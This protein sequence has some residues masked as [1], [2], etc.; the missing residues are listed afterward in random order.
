MGTPHYF[1]KATKY[2]STYQA[3]VQD[4]H[5]PMRSGRIRVYCK[6][7]YGD[8][9]SPW[10]Q[11]KHQ[12][13]LWTIP[14]EGSKVW[15]T[16]RHGDPRYPIWEGSWTTFNPDTM[17]PEFYELS[18]GPYKDDLRDAKDHT[19]PFDVDDHD[20]GHDHSGGKWWN[21][22][23][24]GLRFPS[25]AGLEVNE[26]PGEQRMFVTDR[27]GQSLE[28]T[29]DPITP[30]DPHDETRVGGEYDVPDLDPNSVLSQNENVR[31]RTSLKARHTQKLEW[32]VGQ[33]DLEETLTLESLNIAGDEGTRFRAENSELAFGFKLE[34]FLKSGETQGYE[35]RVDP[36]SITTNHWQRLYDEHG[37]EFRIH[38]D[39]QTPMRWMKLQN[40]LGDYWRVDWD[41]RLMEWTDHNGQSIYYNTDEQV[42]N[43]YIEIKNTPG[44]KIRMDQDQLFLSLE[45]RL[46]NKILF[47]AQTDVFTIDHHTGQNVTMDATGVSVA[48]S[49]GSTVTM[50]AAG[51]VSVNAPTSI[52]LSA[53]GSSITLSASG[54]ALAP[55]T[56]AT[57]NGKLIAVGGNSVIGTDSAGHT[58]VTSSITATG[59]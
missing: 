35:A 59:A 1:N 13:H 50:D 11:P 17:P 3:T 56:T 46:A 38:S 43:R 20:K 27:I 7:V 23:W 2:R 29:G 19:S 10:C 52:T 21:P 45:D 39:P 22:Y 16:F 9:Y 51:N 57:V 37:Q 44:E 18:E 6:Y 42:P 53:G 31:A 49:G 40:G 30:L 5:D 34:R 24:H 36:K 32:T 15:I 25:G 54:I 4:V 55:A 47:N 33:A 28:F 12:S 8:D 58:L 48:D 41:N 14:L 26:E